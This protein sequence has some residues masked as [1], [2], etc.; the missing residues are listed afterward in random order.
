MMKVR[1]LSSDQQR[2]K[3]QLLN[4]AMR[5]FRN[6]PWLEG[7]YNEEDEWRLAK[8]ESDV[9]R[10]T[11]L[12]FC[13]G[14]ITIAR[15]DEVPSSDPVPTIYAF[16]PRTGTHVEMKTTDPIEFLED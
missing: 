16:S 4:S 10:G 6:V 12:V 3:K 9:F 1:K 15:K 5:I 11:T 7:A 14:D 13:N 2:N 8:I